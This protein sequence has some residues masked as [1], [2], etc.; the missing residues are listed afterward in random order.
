MVEKRVEKNQEE[1]QLI[2]SGIYIVEIIGNNGIFTK[3][4]MI[5]I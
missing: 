5:K 2:K 3:K 4:V 1:F